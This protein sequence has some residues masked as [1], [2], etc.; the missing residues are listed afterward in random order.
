MIVYKQTSTDNELQ[1][2]LALQQQNLPQ[3]LSVDERLREGFVTVEHSFDV[4]KMMNKECP[5]T[6]AVDNGKVIGYALSMHPCFG[7]TIP[8]LK[9]MFAEIEKIGFAKNDFI[10][11][12]QICIA[13]SHRRQGVFRGL[14]QNMRAFLFPHFSKIITEVDAKNVRSLNAHL[15][16]GFKEIHRYKSSTKEWVLISL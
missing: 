3:H 2:I 7:D 13:K 11:M 9:P 14:Y 1:Q 4:L 8:I 10:V 12:G 5:H 6:L 15:S 16:I